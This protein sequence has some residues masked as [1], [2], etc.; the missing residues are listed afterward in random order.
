MGS[1]VKALLFSFCC[2]SAASVCEF[3]EQKKKSLIF[4][5]SKADSDSEA[6][7]V[8]NASSMDVE[9]DS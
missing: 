3:I 5:A 1:C 2:T 9:E 4:L 7:T 8:D 6:M